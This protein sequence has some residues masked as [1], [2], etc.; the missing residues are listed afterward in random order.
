MVS[1]LKK[2]PIV[3]LAS[4]AA[5]QPLPVKLR[6]ANAPKIV[7]ALENI[8]QALSFVTEGSIQLSLWLI[9]CLLYEQRRYNPRYF[10]CR[11]I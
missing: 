7:T 10:D 3:K 9:R 6:A 11:D 4:S 1:W 8:D 2:K 5:E